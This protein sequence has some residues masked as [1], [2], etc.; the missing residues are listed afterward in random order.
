MSIKLEVVFSAGQ[1]QF[2]FPYFDGKTIKMNDSISDKGITASFNAMVPKN[3]PKPML[4]SMCM[5]R[6]ITRT[7][8]KQVFLG[9]Y[10]QE[11]KEIKNSP[12]W[13]YSFTLNSLI[14]FCHREEIE[15]YEE[16]LPLINHI[17]KARWKVKPVPFT[18]FAVK[19][20]GTYGLI[21]VII[22]GATENRATP[23][24]LNPGLTGCIPPDHLKII[25][26]SVKESRKKPIASRFLV[27]GRNGRKLV[28]E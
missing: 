18:D 9:R 24:K 1:S 10:E 6:Q 19:T 8:Y 11:A 26:T 27:N 4:D 28:K 21:Q 16:T 7:G 5:I 25:G 13:N 14:D 22:D 23:Y 12:Y 17:E 15:D 20:S 3:A 2:V